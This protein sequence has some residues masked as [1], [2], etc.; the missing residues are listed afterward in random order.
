M[1]YAF[2]TEQELDRATQSPSINKNYTDKQDYPLQKHFQTL[3]ESE[4]TLA[5]LK[6]KSKKP[7]SVAD[8]ALGLF[9]A[10]I[11]PTNIAG[12]ILTSIIHASGSHASCLSVIVTSLFLG[13]TIYIPFSCMNVIRFIGFEAFERKKLKK[14][15]LFNI[16]NNQAHIETVFEDKQLRFS[17]MEAMEKLIEK[18]KFDSTIK[19]S[20]VDIFIDNDSHAF[21]RH[22]MHVERLLQIQTRKQN[23]KKNKEALEKDKYRARALF[24]EA[25]RK[26]RAYKNPS[27]EV[28]VDDE[29]VAALEEAFSDVFSQHEKNLNQNIRHLL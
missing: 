2:E 5:L 18:K 15:I 13:L 25:Y 14:T 22:I 16:G 11:L 23:E 8:R 24:N 10:L 21:V 9:L 26:F 4:E 1:A 29:L 6:E 3:V 12:A 28:P 19:D 7:L 20:L 17:F 27:V